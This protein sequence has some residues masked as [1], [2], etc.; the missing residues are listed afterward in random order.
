[1]VSNSGGRF[2]ILPGG[3]LAIVRRSPPDRSR[4][5]SFL[6]EIDGETW[7]VLALCADDVPGHVQGRGGRQRVTNVR[8]GTPTGEPFTGRPATK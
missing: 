6:A 8:E 2:A 5:R 1:M 3:R 7:Q 4:V